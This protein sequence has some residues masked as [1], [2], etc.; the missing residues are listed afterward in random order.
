MYFD[1][2]YGTMK[3]GY[4]GSF[5]ITYKAALLPQAP[6]EASGPKFAS[7]QEMVRAAHDSTESDMH[8][9]TLQAPSGLFVGYRSKHEK[10][11]QILRP[12]YAN[13]ATTSWL[14][15]RPQT[16][17]SLRDAFTE[18][19]LPLPW[20][21]V[22]EVNG[23]KTW[24]VD[25]RTGKKRTDFPTVS[26]APKMA[27]TIPQGLQELDGTSVV[28][29][30]VPG[31]VGSKS[32]PAEL[33]SVTSG[34]ETRTDFSGSTLDASSTTSRSETSKGKEPRRLG[35]WLIEL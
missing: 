9:H 6:Q 32:I 27:T 16:L 8:R 20:G 12:E 25:R 17:S 1:K 31:T 35:D 30:R 11:E 19:K 13:T 7:A 14:F 23:G 2:H 15:S 18:A 4:S 33:E 3:T 34:T 24:Y 28:Q 10:P 21:Y 5:Q 22:R 29:A 26:W